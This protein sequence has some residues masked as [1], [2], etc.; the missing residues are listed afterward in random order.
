[1]TGIK[2]ADLTLTRQIIARALYMPLLSVALATVCAL[3]VTDL[4]K[5]QTVAAQRYGQDAVNTVAEWRNTITQAKDLSD[6]EKIVLINDFFNTRI[7]FMEDPQAWGEK[8]YWATPLEVMAFRKGDCE[9]FSIAKYTT[10]LLAGVDMS[11]LRITYVKAKIGG[12]YSKVHAAH[13]VLAYYPTPN[14]DPQILDNLV[15]RIQPAS[16]RPDLTPVFGFNSNGLWVGGAATPATKDPGAKL[17][18]WR[19]LLARASAEGLG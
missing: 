5:M 6:S 4:D 12:A 19:D 3:A 16:L 17:S 13:M 10:L 2:L 11:K 18:R 14:A 9:D 1:M 8:D 15:M 7:R